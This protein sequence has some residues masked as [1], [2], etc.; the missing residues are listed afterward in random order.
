MLVVQGSLDVIDRCIWHAA[1]FEDIQPFLGGFL[2][3]DIL[4]QA[5]NICPVFHTVAIRDESSVGLP[6]GEPKAIAKHTKESI[7][8]A[9]E[10]NVTVEGLVTPVWYNRCYK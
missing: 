6:L 1:A 8:P 3:C 9:T 10:K 2:L 5:I 7:V 4:N